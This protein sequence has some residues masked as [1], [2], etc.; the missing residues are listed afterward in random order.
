MD[1]TENIFEFRFLSD[2]RSHASAWAAVYLQIWHFDQPRFSSQYQCVRTYSSPE[3]GS[4]AWTL[5]CLARRHSREGRLA[6]RSEIIEDGVGTSHCALR[7]VTTESSLP[8]YLTSCLSWS[9]AWRGFSKEKSNW[10]VSSGRVDQGDTYVWESEQCEISE[11]SSSWERRCGDLATRQGDG[12][13]WAFMWQNRWKPS[14]LVTYISAFGVFG[15]LGITVA[16]WRQLGGREG[17]K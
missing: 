12:G 9:S 15:G 10:D 13:V 7:L 2:I 3:S 1:T 6:A 8:N 17:Y 4:E 16:K 11:V 5:E 14:P